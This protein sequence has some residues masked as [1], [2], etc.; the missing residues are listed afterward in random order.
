MNWKIRNTWNKHDFQWLPD[1]NIIFAV[2][3]GRWWS[4]ESSHL[5]NVYRKHIFF[6]LWWCKQQ[7][8]K[9]IVSL[10]VLWMKTPLRTPVCSSFSQT[11]F[12]ALVIH[13]TPFW[14]GWKYEAYLVASQLDN[15]LQETGQIASWF[16]TFLPAVSGR[17]QA[18][19]AS[20]FNFKLIWFP[21]VREALHRLRKVGFQVF[22][23]HAPTCR[24]KHRHAK[25]DWYLPFQK[26]CC[27]Q[28]PCIA[29]TKTNPRVKSL[30]SNGSWKLASLVFTHT[31]AEARGSVRN[32]VLRAAAFP[33]LFTVMA[34]M[35]DVLK[36]SLG[37]RWTQWT[38]TNSGR[39]SED[40][41]NFPSWKE[42]KERRI[43]FKVD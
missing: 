33:D 17:D 38:W 19:S 16:I 4:F 40:F 18:V 3:T 27:F 12:A 30:Q 35:A 29:S 10:R 31:S 11:H 6:P 15:G 20:I 26:I 24:E 22:G 14:I 39:K 41:P 21:N 34:V 23:K 2:H 13:I 5:L 7:G 42:W 28:S 25:C 32:Y 37:P 43:F 9:F 8:L 36:Q 1:I